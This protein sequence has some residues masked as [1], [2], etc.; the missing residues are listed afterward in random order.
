[1]IGGHGKSFTTIQSNKCVAFFNLIRIRATERVTRS[2]TRQNAQTRLRPL[3]SKGINESIIAINDTFESLSMDGSLVL[4][5]VNRPNDV[6]MDYS[7]IFCS[8]NGPNDVVSRS[9]LYLVL[10]L[11]VVCLST[12]TRMIQCQCQ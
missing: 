11:I 2:S 8:D 6:V 10:K 1:M 4:C 5:S 9:H 12:S 7:V 3:A